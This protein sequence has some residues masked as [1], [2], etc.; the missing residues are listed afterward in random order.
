MNRACALAQAPDEPLRL[1]DC[2]LPKDAAQPAFIRAV[3][4]PG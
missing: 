2:Q 1:R 3:R 4:I